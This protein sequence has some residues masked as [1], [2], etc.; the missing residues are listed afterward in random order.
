MVYTRL[1]RAK[2][3]NGDDEFHFQSQHRYLAIRFFADVFLSYDP[4]GY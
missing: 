3:T 4:A 2:N 1:Q